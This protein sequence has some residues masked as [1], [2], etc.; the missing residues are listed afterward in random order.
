MI[1]AK[2]KNNFPAGSIDWIMS[3][4]G[5]PMNLLGRQS[6]HNNRRFTQCQ[7]VV[8]QDKVHPPA[9][10]NSHSL[11]N[12]SHK[13]QTPIRRVHT[14]LAPRRKGVILRNFAL[15]SLITGLINGTT[16]FELYSLPGRSL[17]FQKFT[18]HP[19]KHYAN[20]SIIAH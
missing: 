13:K 9:F 2:V 16:S 8:P 15:Q 17:S 4:L 1:R 20:S 7:P 11:L 14:K 19:T 6:F 18:C 10:S 5:F 3:F 12:E